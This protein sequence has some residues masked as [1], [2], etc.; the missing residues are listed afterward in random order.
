[1]SSEELFRRFPLLPL[2]LLYVLLISVAHLCGHDFGKKPV[3]PLPSEAQVYE[4]TVISYP[5]EKLS[6]GGALVALSG[7]YGTARIA[8]FNTVLPKRG[9]IIRFRSALHPPRNFGNDREWDFELYCRNR[10]IHWTGSVSGKDGWISMAPPAGILRPWLNS[11]R[12]RA[13]EKASFFLESSRRAL[14]SSL[15]LGDMSQVSPEDVE[16]F[17][18]AGVLHLLVVSGSHVGLIALVAGWL[19]GWLL[20]RSSWLVERIPVWKV[21]IVGGF[22]G[23]LFLC[24]LIDLPLPTTRALMALAFFTLGLLLRRPRGG[25]NLWVVIGLIILALRP[26]YLFDISFQLSFAA[27]GGIMLMAPYF[28]SQGSTFVRALS[29]LFLSSLGAFLATLPILIWHFSRLSAW[30]LMG[31]LILVPL[32]GSVGIPVGLAATFTTGRLSELLFVL[33][34]RWLELSLPILKW[35]AS[36]HGTDL[37]IPSPPLIGWIGF[38]GL[39]ALFFIRKLKF[40]TAEYQRIAGVFFATLLLGSFVS[41]KDRS[42]EVH[43]IHVG[44]GDATLIQSEEGKTILVDAGPGGFHSFDAGER[45]IVPWFRVHG[46]DRIDVL[47]ITHGDSDHA[48]G[49]NSILK[50]IEVGEVWYPPV[51]R[52]SVVQATYETALSKRIPWK[53]MDA[54]FP[55]LVWKGLKVETLHPSPETVL[56]SDNNRALVLMAQIQKIRLLLASDIEAEA[57]EEIL[58]K[59]HGL[60]AEIL[61]V[62]H[63]GSHTSSS[64]AFLAAVSPWEAVMEVGWKNRFGHPHLEVLER[65]MG[66]H[67]RIWRGDLCGEVVAR[68]RETEMEMN[69]IRSCQKSLY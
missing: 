30:S 55:P 8:F 23:A 1:M 46:M 58:R 18:K 15:V 20:R 65:Y 7:N 5:E 61:K 29:A 21:Q 16:A 53:S 26:G 57:E 34:D 28:R 40:F 10:D 50:H 67:I 62:P 52:P 41:K 33:F 31:N 64:P 43:F 63:H 9:E 24:S 42:A 36:L 47:A 3:P 32:L 19:L 12:E 22:L 48:G 2:T 69:A 60:H 6:G 38:A 45:V 4:G 25:W 14:Y 54:S 17:R 68:I 39:F 51:E 59:N 66:N 37:Y 27:V 13:L 49:A 11:L 44:Q 35:V 56:E